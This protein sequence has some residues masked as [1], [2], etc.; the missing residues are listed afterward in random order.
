MCNWIAV[1]FFFFFFFFF[2]FSS[3]SSDLQERGGKGFG[4]SAAAAE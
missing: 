1:G 3:W 4:A 2:F